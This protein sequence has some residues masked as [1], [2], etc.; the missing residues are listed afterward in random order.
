M[1]A[2]RAGYRHSADTIAKIRASNLGKKHKPMPE[3]AKRKLSIAGAETIKRWRKRI[4]HLDRLGRLWKFRSTW[5]L[6]FAQK[7]D[8]AELTWSFEPHRL[9]LSTGRVYVP[10]FWVEEWATYVEIKGFDGW[11]SK[12][13]WQQAQT[14]GHPILLISDI[15]TE[16]HTLNES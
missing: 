4:E 6:R 1:I 10:D 5:E 8:V 12:G 13:K 2:A 15:E 9:L 7:L 3:S 16:I 14:D 11:G